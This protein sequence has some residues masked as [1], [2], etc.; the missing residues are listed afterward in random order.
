MKRPPLQSAN[1]FKKEIPLIRAKFEISFAE[2]HLFLKEVDRFIRKQVA[3]FDPALVGYLSY[4]LETRGKNLRP[5]LVLLAGGVSGQI[6]TDHIKLA[7]VVELIHLASLV[8]DDILDHAEMRRGKA[9]AHARWGP[10][11]AVLLGDCLFAHALKLCTRFENRRVA[12]K[13]AEAASDLIQG[14]IL[15]TQRQFDL[16]FSIEDYFRI[17]G[18]KTAAL[19]EVCTEL[20]ALLNQVNQEKQESFR[21]FGRHLG[22]A[23]QIYDDCLDLVGTENQ[24]G[25]TLGTDLVKGKLTLPILFYLQTLQG[26]DLEKAH[27]I[28]LSGELESY[29]QLIQAIHASG[30][31]R[32]AIESFIK[33]IDASRAYL[34]EWKQNVYRNGLEKFLETLK[35]QLEPL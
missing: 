23:Y 26:A 2:I 13:V 19:F 9:T 25:K 29:Y 6:Q 8:H 24:T 32:H 33:E 35:Q 12:E 30:Q 17:I 1:F 31:F 7:S 18:M 5:A 11:T 22:I 14:E 20:S 10:E 27:E 3:A 34:T 4:V 16:T 21:Q 28:I 15:Q